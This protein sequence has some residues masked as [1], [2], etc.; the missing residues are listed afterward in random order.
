MYIFAWI[1]FGFFIVSFTFRTSVVI[2]KCIAIGDYNSG[3]TININLFRMALDIAVFVFI[4]I[5]L[6]S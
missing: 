4:C 5:Y 1:L 3:V 2:G 6:F